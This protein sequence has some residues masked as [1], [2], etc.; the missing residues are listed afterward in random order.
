MGYRPHEIERS[1]LEVKYNIDFSE[2]SDDINAVKYIIRNLNNLSSFEY[3]SMV[4]QLNDRQLEK[5]EH[6]LMIL[7][8]HPELK[9]NLI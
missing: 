4:E 3:D 7:I 9:E 8:K 6:Y 2:Y 1:K 5:L